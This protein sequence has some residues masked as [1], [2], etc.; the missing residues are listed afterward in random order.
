MYRTYRYRTVRVFYDEAIENA[1]LFITGFKGFGAVGYITTLHMAEKLGCSRAGFI[2]T[3]YMPEEATLDK[4]GNIVGAFTLY[5]CSV[6]GKRVVI[7]VNHDIP[8]PQERERFAEAVIG[9]LEQAAIDE[10]VFVGGFDSR[11]RKGGEELRW[12]HTSTY[13]RRIDAPLMEH[14]LYVVGPLALLLLAAEIREYPAA[15]VLPYAEA[16]RPDP[17]AAAVAV[18]VIG[19]LYGIEVGV[20]DLLEEARKIEEMIIELEKQQREAMQPAGS[21]RVYM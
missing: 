3:K 20:E 19:Q 14:G 8:L 13:K 21:E 6:S 11:F 7:L 2:V 1:D 5:G 17:R 12:L 15:V 4:A 9:F 16:A 10:A 18:R